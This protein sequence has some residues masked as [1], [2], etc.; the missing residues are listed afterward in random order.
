MLNRLLDSDDCKPIEDHEL[1]IFN[2]IELNKYLIG[3]TFENKSG[4]KKL[5]KY[6]SKDVDIYLKQKN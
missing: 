5:K 2:N 3:L 1:C 4:Y 6:I